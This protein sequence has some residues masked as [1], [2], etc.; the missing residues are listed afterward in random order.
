MHRMALFRLSTQ[1]KNQTDAFMKGFHVIINPSLI[2]C[3]SPEELQKLIS[4][5]QVDIDI[6]DLRLVF[7]PL[8]K[9]CIIYYR[10]R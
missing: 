5:D 4:G 1:I 10:G 3:F 7:L 2:K 9:T 8:L 6:D